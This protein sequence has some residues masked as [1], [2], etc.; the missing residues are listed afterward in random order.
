MC[1]IAFHH[2]RTCGCTHCIGNVNLLTLGAHAQPGYG[3]SVVCP[4]SNSLL[5]GIFVP[6]MIRRNKR[7]SLIERF[8]LKMLRCRDLSVHSVCGKRACALYDHVAVRK[9]KTFVCAGVTIFPWLS[10]L[11]A[12]FA[13]SIPLKLKQCKCCQHV[14][15]KSR[16]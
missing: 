1:T 8:S 7:I 13:H 10:C 9:R 5:D 6:Q 12:R 16:I 2:V 14:F 15:Q 11:Q 4:C 3:S